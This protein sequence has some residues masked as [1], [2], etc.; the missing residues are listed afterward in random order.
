MYKTSGVHFTMQ[1]LVCMVKVVNIVCSTSCNVWA[2][3]IAIEWLPYTNVW[4]KKF[5]H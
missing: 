3:N 2:A 1:L 4:K 5:S